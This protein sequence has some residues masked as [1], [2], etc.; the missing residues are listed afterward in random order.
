MTEPPG[1]TFGS[2]EYP[3]K[4]TVCMAQPTDAVRIS[5]SDCWTRL[6]RNERTRMDTTAEYIMTKPYLRQEP[7]RGGVRREATVMTVAWGR[8]EGSGH[9]QRAHSREPKP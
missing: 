2:S 1:S 9:G 6:K 5:P 3:A 7:P 8:C 4:Q